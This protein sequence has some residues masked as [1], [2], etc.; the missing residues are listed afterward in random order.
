MI[1]NK[2]LKIVFSLMLIILISG[3]AL[4]SRFVRSDILNIFTFSLAGHDPYDFCSNINSDFIKPYKNG[5]NPSKT[6]I[7]YE[8]YTCHINHYCNGDKKCESEARNYWI[9][10]W[11]DRSGKPIDPVSA[12]ERYCKRI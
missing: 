2:L 11:T 12:A 4:K 9:G 3:C 8:Y 1:N 7:N 6:C 5:A 10:N